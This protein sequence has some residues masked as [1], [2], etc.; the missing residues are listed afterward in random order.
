MGIQ[1]VIKLSPYEFSKEAFE[2]LKEACS[3]NFY[4]VLNP[5]ALP[6]NLPIPL[7]EKSFKAVV[8][9]SGDM[10]DLVYMVNLLRID[11]N[12]YA[13]DQEPLIITYHESQNDLDLT[14]SFI[15]HGNWP[16]RTIYPGTG[17]FAA[18]SA[19]GIME[20]YP[21][22]G[23]PRNDYGR[24]EDLNPDSQRFA[25]WEGVQAVRFIKK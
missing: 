3:P 17:F 7:I 13:V 23:V 4:R 1:R 14:A 2:S 6:F 5:S 24:I 9:G 22:V 16:G 21:Y 11:H 10:H 12:D 19:S 20:H 18:I 25:F 15:H 8:V